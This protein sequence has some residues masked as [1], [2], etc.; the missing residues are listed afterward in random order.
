MLIACFVVLLPAAALA[1]EKGLLDIAEDMITLAEAT[2]SCAAPEGLCTEADVSA[3]KADAEN[4]LRDI[5][6][7]VRAGNLKS[8]KFSPDHIVSLNSRLAS[9]KSQLV[10]GTLLETACNFGIFLLGTAEQLIFSGFYL[11]SFAYLLSGLALVPVA[12]LVLL[13]CF[14]WWL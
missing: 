1:G 8:M 12:C 13:T 7:A 4:G 5:V 2:I 6:A 9:L 10:H 3:L 14:F 11:G